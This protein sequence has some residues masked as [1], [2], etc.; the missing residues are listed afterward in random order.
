MSLIDD[1]EFYGRAVDASE[2]EPARAAVL[3][4]D[5]HPGRFSDDRALDALET[6][7]TARTDRQRDLA[8]LNFALF[9]L[10]HGLPLEEWARNRLRESA[11]ADAARMLRRLRREWRASA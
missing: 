5:A 9:G 8:D 6:W 1:I 7:Q 2:L 4:Q 11:K 3:L 10:E